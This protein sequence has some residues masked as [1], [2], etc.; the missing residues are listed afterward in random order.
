[1]DLRRDKSRSCFVILLMLLLFQI[2]SE[3]IEGYDYIAVEEPALNLLFST[4]FGEGMTD[5]ITGISAGPCGYFYI[6]GD[7]YQDDD[8]DCFFAKIKDDGSS[9]EY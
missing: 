6:V 4:Y 8:W 3:P 1:M 7:S 5:R 2:A 9:I